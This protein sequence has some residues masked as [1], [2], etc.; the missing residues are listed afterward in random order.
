MN[1]KFHMKEDGKSSISRIRTEMSEKRE[2]ERERETE[3]ENG[4]IDNAL[5]ML[6]EETAWGH[7]GKREG[8]W[9]CQRQI[10]IK[11]SAAQTSVRPCR[12]VKT[13]GHIQDL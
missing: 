9:G 10:H 4:G 1:M 5:A 3:M 13:S 11:P 6:V 8:G 2:R 7:W 12:S